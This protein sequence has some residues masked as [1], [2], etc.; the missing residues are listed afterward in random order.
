[1][2]NAVRDR[3]R[4]KSDAYY[5]PEHLADAVLALLE[6]FEC[7]SNTPMP[8]SHFRS[9][10]GLY[11]V[12]DHR[13]AISR[14][15]VEDSITGWIAELCSNAEG[16]ASDFAPTCRPDIVF[17]F[18]HDAHGSD[19]TVVLEA[20]LVWHRWIDDGMQHYA[21]VTIDEIGRATGNYATQNIG[22]VVDD[23][24]KL[25]SRYT[26]FRDRHMLLCIV[27]QRPG[28]L[29]DRII[30]AVGA[31]WSVRSRHIIDRCCPTGDDLGCTGMVFWPTNPRRE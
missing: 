10:T 11:A 4:S 22:Q 29:D 21:G 20:K 8:T 30:N 2:S 9:R 5:E 27:F 24:D 18:D 3:L 26:D 7:A 6:Y 17:G 13:N 14:G 1:M 28:E 25:L 31:G 16:Q 15:A 19:V 12:P 23:R